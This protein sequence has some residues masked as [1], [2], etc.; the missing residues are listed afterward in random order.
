MCDI[1]NYVSSVSGPFGTESND[2]LLI[3]RSEVTVSQNQ[4]VFMEIIKFFA[5]ND[6][7]VMDFH[8]KNA[9]SKH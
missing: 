4:G 6:L 8:L 5:Q 7:S 3:F 9:K 2:A 1:P